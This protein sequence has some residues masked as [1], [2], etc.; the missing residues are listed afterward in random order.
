MIQETL[1]IKGY[2]WLY[3]RPASGLPAEEGEWT[4][5]YET[6]NLVTSAGKILVARLLADESGQDTGITHCEVG[7]DDTYS[8]QEYDSAGQEEWR[9]EQRRRALPA[10]G[11]VHG[12][13]AGAGGN[14]P[15]EDYDDDG[16]SGGGCTQPGE[17][18]ERSPRR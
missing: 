4:L 7:T 1:T 6:P 9:A 18:R 8:G 13:G 10:N 16:A 11:E 15:G 2:I 5:E 14:N 12:S 17:P 3:S